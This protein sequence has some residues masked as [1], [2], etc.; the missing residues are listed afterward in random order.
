M[1]TVQELIDEFTQ[2]FRSRGGAYS[3]WYIGITAHPRRRLFDDHNVSEDSGKW[4]YRD[5]GTHGKARS[6]E[7]H[8]VNRGMSG[9]Q[10][11]GGSAT[12]Y[13]YTY[14]KTRSTQEN[15]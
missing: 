9:G 10:G 14:K 2:Y 8:F 12:T 11:G 15:N 3:G 5:A 7:E 13:V 6:V 4:K 1:A